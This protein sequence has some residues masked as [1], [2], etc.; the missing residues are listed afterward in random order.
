M[1]AGCV[2]WAKAS[3]DVQ[4]AMSPVRVVSG[5]SAVVPDT[6]IGAALKSHVRK[7]TPILPSASARLLGYRHPSAAPHLPND[8][9]HVRH[10]LGTSSSTTGTQKAQPVA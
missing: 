1:R 3:P 5:G 6:V 7:A 8:A 9:F 2:I 4:A 10:Y